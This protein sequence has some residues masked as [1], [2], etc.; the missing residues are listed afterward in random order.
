MDTKKVA[1]YAGITA[2][3]LLAGAGIYYFATQGEAEAEKVPQKTFDQLVEEMRAE[4][5]KSK[6][7]EKMDGAKISGE[8]ILKVFHV[9]TKYTAVAKILDNEDAFN[10]RIEALR[11]GNNEEYEKLRKETD[12]EENKRMQHLQDVAMA[13]FGTTENEYIQGYQ[14]N[15]LQPAFI[16]KMQGLQ[17]E[18]VKEIQTLNPDDELPEALTKEKAI[19]IRDFAK[20]E[21]QKKIMELQS[22][23]TNQNEFQ[24][25][26]MY[27]VSKLDDVIFINYGFKNTDV[28]KAFQQFNL[29]PK[30]GGGMMQGG[31]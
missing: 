17:T 12:A 11:E 16:Q 21:T 2:A 25:K 15:L 24:E 26:F 28:L 14:G 20:A 18:I 31:M 5:A 23:M 1:T 8:F 10:K 29:I 3:V 27:E 9:L 13:D 4:I 22:T 6:N 19:E 7:V 30:Q